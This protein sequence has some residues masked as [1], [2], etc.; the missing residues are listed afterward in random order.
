MLHFLS[1]LS[2]LI[3]SKSVHAVQVL[4]PVGDLHIVNKEIAPDGFSRPA[5]LA[6]GSPDDASFPGPL[7]AATKGSNFQ[8]NVVNSLNDTRMLRSTSIHWH[9]IFQSK[10]SW[11][12]GAIGIAQCPITPGE[13]FLYEFSTP[14]QAGTFWYHSHYSTQ[15][16]DGL[17][18]PL[19]LYDSDDPYRWSYDVDDASTVITLADWY[20]TPAPQAQGFPTP[21]S[22]LINGKGRYTGGPS[23]PLS[24]VNVKGGLRYRFRLFSLACGPNYVFSIDSHK[25]TV[26]EAEGNNVHQV[27]VDSIQIFAGQRY[28]FILHADQPASNY[29]VR[30]QP[31]KG[32]QGFQN[33]INS[34]IMRYVGAPTQDP[35]TSQSSNP[36]LLKETDLHS[37]FDF[38]APGKGYPGG[39]DVAVNL[40]VEFGP[41]GFTVNGVSFDPPSIPALLQILSGKQ[42]AQDLLPSGSIY[43]LPPN[44]VVEV[45]I[46]GS[47]TGAPHP[48]HL[49][50][51]SFSVVR[52]AGSKTY[53]YINPVIRDVVST[54]D[55][56][57]N[58]TI[59][60]TTDNAGPWIFHCHI[61]WH[62]QQGLAVVFAEDVQ[63]IAKSKPPTSWD[64]L[65]PNYAKFSET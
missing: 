24:V 57:D 21:D 55:S 25:L 32:Q 23:V 27:K 50:G 37:L 31:N 20:H 28:S 65:C 35:T 62:L 52:S 30:A 10:T 14:N 60:F 46:A 38:V 39:A 6:G 15:Y 43:T 16:C 3:L 49:H 48:F 44:K 17:R 58:V 29:W 11:A 61:D 36:T 47:N 26:I 54:G 12:D 41:S 18:G 56:N 13:S 5:V 19:V 7:I 40:D 4:G 33:G 1:L 63:T 42:T 34:A 51:H 53:N 64:Q 2:L 45:T 9:G 59:R 22:T 8:M